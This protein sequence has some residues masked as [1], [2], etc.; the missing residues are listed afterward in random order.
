MF[1]GHAPR[2]GPDP[3]GWRQ[4]QLLFLTYLHRLGKGVDLGP[5]VEPIRRNE[6]DVVITDAW[7]GHF[8]R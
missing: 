6:Y 5:S 1:V 7:A 3:A 8:G 4:H 2:E